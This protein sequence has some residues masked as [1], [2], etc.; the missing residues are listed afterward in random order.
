MPVRGGHS[1]RVFHWA[2]GV[3]PAMLVLR[4][5]RV[6]LALGLML[7]PLALVSPLALVT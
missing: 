4:I 3:L 7:R 6:G 1:G 5:N 2:V